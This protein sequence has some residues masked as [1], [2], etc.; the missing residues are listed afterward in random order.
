M[1]EGGLVWL[2]GNAPQ[3]SSPGSIGTDG[4]AGGKVKAA[5]IAVPFCSVS[6]SC[7]HTTAALAAPKRS[8]PALEHAVAQEAFLKIMR[9]PDVPPGSPSTSLAVPSVPTVHECA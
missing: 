7:L 4:R 3:R 9:R 8:Q 6:R 5:G 2:P 1:A